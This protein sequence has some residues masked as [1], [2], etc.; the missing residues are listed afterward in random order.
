MKLLELS[1]QSFR[2]L[3]D[4]H[5]LPSPG[6]TLAVG[7]NG[8]GKTNLLE[9]LYYL[10]TLK[11][12]RASRL[13]ELVQFGQARARVQ[14]RLL[15]SG[16]ER[17]ISVEIAAAERQL[18]VD[19][20][21]VARLDE[22]F[23]GVSV[24]AFTPDDLRAIKGGPEGRR[25]LLDRAVFN[26]FPA[27]LSESRAYSR[28][29]KARNR[30]LKE[31][32]EPRY[33][34]AYDEAVAKGGAR[35]WLRR[36]ALLKELAPR[37]QAAFSAIGPNFPD[38]HFEYAPSGLTLEGGQGEEE[39]KALLLHELTARRPSD[40]ERGFTQVGPHADDVAVALGGKSSRM[41]AS[42]G[43]QRAL[44]LAWKI[45]E[46]ESLSAALGMKPLL[47]LDDVSSELD[48]ER[49]D[50]LMGYLANTGAQVILTTT[51]A[52]LVRRAAGADSACYEV[53]EGRMT[54]KSARQ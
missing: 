44:V 28:A 2:N 21:K 12:L 32:A 1:A 46:I 3:T 13:S 10:C 40:F 25:Q 17:E 4:I 43:Q 14:A 48:A 19:G 39:L 35:L 37:A 29:L 49:N 51:D 20:K 9:A 50:Y 27:F 41:F 24:V 45:A 15:L 54:V 18:F 6:T 38:A 16:V 5:L 23:Q 7:K 52:S 33:L 47:L 42:Q 36:Q 26:R 8:Q 34:D 30:L 31:R 11:P 53:S 22:Y